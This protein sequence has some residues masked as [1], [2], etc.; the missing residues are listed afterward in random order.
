MIFTYR[1]GLIDAT[2]VLPT[3]RFNPITNTTVEDN[4][5][6]PEFVRRTTEP[7]A[8]KNLSYPDNFGKAS[9]YA[10]RLKTNNANNINPEQKY[11]K[12][13]QLNTVKETV[14][15]KLQVERSQKRFTRTKPL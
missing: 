1:P 15:P 12:Y 4:I 5:I 13:G 10:T 11:N 7:A 6:D 8:F 9:K 14:T 3:P 2:T